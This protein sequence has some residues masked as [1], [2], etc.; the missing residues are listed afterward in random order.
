[1]RNI[2]TIAS[3]EFRLFFSTPIAYAIAFVILLTV[4]VVVGINLLDAAQYAMYGGYV[5]DSTIITGT[6]AFLF[7]LSLPA[8]TMRLLA[9]EQRNGTLELLLTSPIRDHEL[10]I[11]KWLGAFLFVLLIILSTLV[12]AIILNGV[13]D[14]GIDQGLMVASY[15]GI[16]L[17]AAAFL[18]IGIGISA[19]FDNQLAAFFVTLIVLMILWWMIG[20]PANL[21]PTGGDFF[22]YMN[23]QNHFY[24][25]FNRGVIAVS[26][27][28]YFLS[29]TGLGLFLGSVSIEM[30]RWR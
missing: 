14:P 7:V 15:L 13:I 20:W 28:V 17:V 25:T 29:L 30:R 4:G 1:M 11:G 22:R 19:M 18:G 26:D 27:L 10:V 12:Y 5:P 16:I 3:R 6:M 8:V 9:D 23:M 24:E 21:L 2:W